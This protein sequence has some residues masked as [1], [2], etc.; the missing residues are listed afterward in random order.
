[1]ILD[2][3]EPAFGNSLFESDVKLFSRNAIDYTKLYEIFVEF[4]NEAILAE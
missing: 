4:L 2:W 3:R 1:V